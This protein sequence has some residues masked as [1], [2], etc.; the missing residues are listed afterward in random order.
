MVVSSGSA[1][2]VPMGVGVGSVNSGVV[3]VGVIVLERSWSGDGVIVVVGDVTLVALELGDLV[4]EAEGDGL[5]VGVWQGPCVLRARYCDHSRSL[6]RSSLRP[7]GKLSQINKF[8]VPSLLGWL[9]W[10]LVDVE[11]LDTELEVGEDAITEEVTVGV[12]DDEGEVVGPGA[13]DGDGDGPAV[14]DKDGVV[15]GELVADAGGVGVLV[16][17][18]AGHPASGAGTR[19]SG[20]SMCG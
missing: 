13:I 7:P 12:V 10:L 20:L 5:G 1:I 9:L 19:S 6:M 8:C 16:C 18:L 11:G 15:V 14:G 2:S 17:T 3:G 4:I